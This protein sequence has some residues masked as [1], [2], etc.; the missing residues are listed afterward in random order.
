MIAYLKGKLTYKSRTDVIVEVS[1]GVGYQVHITL[2]TYDKIAHL[3]EV[4][5]LTHFIVREDAQLLY[6]FAE[7]D[8]KA[9]F[10]HLISVSGVG[11]NTARLMLSSLTADQV[12]HAIIGE[13]VQLLRGVK[14]IGPKSA[15]RIILELKDKLLKD[16]GAVSEAIAASLGG[17]NPLR[18]EAL[19]AL[20]ALGFNKIEVQKTLNR[21]LKERSEW[22]D[23][24][25]LIKQAL[26]QL[27]G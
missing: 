12:R 1:G 6:G 24:G 14:G 10:E 25:E 19:A 2:N 27:A 23:S 21:L 20:V 18:E 11:P 26:G 16:S 15:A 8:E 17:E 22:R 5:L 7:P 3:N 9:M 4:T 13:Q